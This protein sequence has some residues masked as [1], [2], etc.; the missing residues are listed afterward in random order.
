M[1]NCVALSREV[2]GRAGGECEACAVCAGSV[3]T[4]QGGEGELCLV[5]VYHDEN[6]VHFVSVMVV[7]V[8]RVFDV[9]V[10]DAGG[11]VSAL[12][13]VFEMI[14]AVHAS[15][16]AFVA[17]DGERVAVVEG[18][19]GGSYFVVADGNV[20]DVSASENLCV[21][22]CRAVLV[23]GDDVGV[24]GWFLLFLAC[25]FLCPR[26]VGVVRLVRALLV[27]VEVAAAGFAAR[28]GAFAV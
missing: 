16:A 17:F 5:A 10:H 21:F 2:L 18:E 13:G 20:G 8:L 25:W 14:P 19:G 22:F 1:V 27:V 11:V 28:A 12:V 15:H 23:E 4:S 7:V 9:G 24:H 3:V 26:V 6:G